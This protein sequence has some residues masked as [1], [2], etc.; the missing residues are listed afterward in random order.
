M[1]EL[2]VSLCCWTLWLK[3]AF[4]FIGLHCFTKCLV[5]HSCTVI[6]LKL[7]SSFSPKH[8]SQL[9]YHILAGQA[10]RN[11]HLLASCTFE[12][13][14]N[15]VPTLTTFFLLG[16]MPFI[17]MSISLMFKVKSHLVSQNMPRSGLSVLSG[18]F[19]LGRGSLNSSNF[20]LGHTTSAHS[21]QFSV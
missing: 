2:T 20:C 6:Q 13:S 12:R 3:H 21:H 19:S 18:S 17:K 11:V 8:P 14:K 15:L 1:N 5:K 7:L 16:W 9:S 4:S 10:V